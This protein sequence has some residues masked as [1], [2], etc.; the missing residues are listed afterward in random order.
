MGATF[1]AI[2]SMFL[3]QNFGIAYFGSIWQFWPVMLIVMG[4]ARMLSPRCGS[5]IL[6][7]LMLIGLGVI[8]LL[9]NLGILYGGVGAYIWPLGM[10]AFGVSMLVR[11]LDRQSQGRLQ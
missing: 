3:L 10:I 8:F 11:R 9:R 1:V 7:G 2:G 4:V 6:S 5:G